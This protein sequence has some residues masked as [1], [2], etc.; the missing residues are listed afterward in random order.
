[1][2]C[3]RV[4]KI[5]GLLGTV[6]YHLFG[7]LAKR[8]AEY[9]LSPSSPTK[10]QKINQEADQPNAQNP[11]FIS[12]ILANI[13]SHLLSY[14]KAIYSLSNVNKRWKNYFTGISNFH[15]KSC[16]FF[17]F[18]QIIRYIIPRFDMGKNITFIIHI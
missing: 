1:V 13:F 9:A 7:M 11:L 12:E 14:I 6:F 2:H 17:F 5:L 3:T 10:K 15:Q 4:G 8:K 16:L 18:I